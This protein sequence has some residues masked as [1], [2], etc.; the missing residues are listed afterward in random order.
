MKR[1]A[2]C[3]LFFFCLPL[4]AENGSAPLIADPPSR[5]AIS[6]DGMWNTIID[7]YESGPD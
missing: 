2:A 5:T 4:L 3:L 1:A 6:L 7:P